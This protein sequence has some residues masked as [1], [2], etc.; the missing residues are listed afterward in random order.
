MNTPDR[1]PKSGGRFLI[2]P[3]GTTPILAREGFS[4]E[5][6]EIEA[7]V[8][9]FAREQIL[10]NKA[11]LDGY[12][13]DLSL[14]LL[15]QMGELGLLGI[16]VPEDYGGLEMD[17][18][19]TAIVGEALSSGWC[20]SFTATYSVQ[21][22]IGSLPI[23][24]FGTPQQKQKYLPRLVTG[25]WVG[26]YG[27]T[28]PGA[29]SDALAG[30]TSARLSE[31]GKNYLLNGEKI[32]ITNG[33]WANL[34]I[35]FAKIDGHQ[36]SAFIVERDTPGLEVGAEEKKLGMKG[37][38]TTSLVFKDA[39]VPVENLLYE[40]GKGATIAFNVLN[41]GRFKLAAH[42]LGG[43]KV[44]LAEAARYA[45]QRR[46][47]GQPI[48]H[49]DVI[50]GKIAD[51]AIRIYSA[52]SMIYRTIGLIQDEIATLDKSDPAFYIHQGEAT[53]RYAIEASM[54]KVYSSES[55]G[56]CSDHGIQILGG[57]GFMEEYPMAGAYRDTRIDRIW[58]GTN[59]INRQ[60]ITGYLLKKALLEELPIRDQIMAIDS[61]LT[62][63]REDLEGLLER[64][65]QAIETGKRLTLF[66]LH[67][68]LCEFGQDLKHQQQLTENL[69]NML[70]DLY[71]SDSTLQRVRQC[72]AAGAS[73]TVVEEVARVHAAEVCLRLLS[74]SLTGLNGIY[75]GSL[76][77][78][79]ID[80]LR[81]FQ[82][83]MLLPTDIMGLKRRIAEA[84]YARKEY[85][86]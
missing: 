43:C 10:P 53:E 1:P 45:L 65:V 15:R 23:V 76:P 80:H 25:E 79:V 9:D 57:N 34:Y 69:A 55:F 50:K 74:L 41:L 42:D 7:L 6:R 86:F 14:K 13:R 48:A 59:E 54:A 44:V 46:Q 51:M 2:E 82:R 37:T 19:T 72:A 64:E 35:I 47:F 73:V 28:E 83:H 78:G 32:F 21:T 71:T 67:E 33:G 12:D 24:W 38:S 85:P 27:L 36:F 29:G 77:A 62:R 26:A 5:H 17:K 60:I 58:E 56:L 81:F 63:E 30:K 4:E 39:P 18:I 70:I 22:G 40:A 84:V 16:D 11:A 61:F 52:D 8:K 20:G 3:V 75:R 49:F 31:D 66:I 68:A